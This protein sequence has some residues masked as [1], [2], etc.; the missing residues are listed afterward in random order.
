MDIVDI[1]KIFK[2]FAGN[3]IILYYH[4]KRIVIKKF[5]LQVF[6]DYLV[7]SGGRHKIKLMSNYSLI[8][9]VPCALLVTGQIVY[10]N[11][12]VDFVLHKI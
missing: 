9:I 2:D 11:T 7:I 12:E 3:K 8:N 1:T 6:S 4:G 5:D 10:S